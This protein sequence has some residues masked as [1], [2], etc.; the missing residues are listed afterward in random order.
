MRL[1][2]KTVGVFA[3]AFLGLG[4]I[5]ACFGSMIYAITFWMV[6]LALMNIHVF[7]LVRERKI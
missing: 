4:S 2:L 6:G 3:V 1:N 7:I 5:P